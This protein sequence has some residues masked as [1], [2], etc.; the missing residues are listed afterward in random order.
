MRAPAPIAAAVSLSVVALLSG[1]S[2]KSAPPTPKLGPLPNASAPAT[3]RLAFFPNVTHAPAL[4][5]SARGEFTKAFGDGVKVEEQSFNAG[6]S[7]I[8]AL[9]AGQ[10]D[11]GYI[12]PG[13][14]INGYVKSKGEALRIVAGACSG[15]AS[16]VAREDVAISGV[17]DLAGKRVAVPQIGGT[18]DI[19]L[20]HFLSTV[21]L[22]STDR[23]GNVTIQPVQNADVLPLFVKK[24]LDAAWVPEPWVARL[25]AEVKG[26]LVVDERDLWPTKQ[27]PTTIVIVRTKFLQEHRDLV[28]KFLAAH[29]AS[30]EW[31][32]KNPAEAQK[33][34]GQRIKELTK[35]T[36]PAPVLADSL[37]RCSMTADPM[38][39]G[40]LTFADWSKALGYQRGGREALSGLFEAAAEA[41]APAAKP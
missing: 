32:A 34:V 26:R 24:E 28:D 27:F 20:R 41:K 21:G 8:E 9:F 40:V 3:V 33:L 12:G 38:Q 11:I 17:K 30:I 13:P 37:T 7:E 15:G 19:S 31:I 2:P 4:V 6:P 16:L 1:C 18:Q 29:K 22:T 36:L 25:K 23:G 14:A 10:V 39:D 5:A 35:K